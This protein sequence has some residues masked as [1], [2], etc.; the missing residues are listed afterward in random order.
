MSIPI[1]PSQSL[2]ELAAGVLLGALENQST[3]LA[4]RLASATSSM[5]ERTARRGSAYSEGL[6]RG[7]T[8]RGSA[9]DSVIERRAE[10]L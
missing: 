7:L 8:Q 5:I 2:P 3:E 10:S 6:L 9:E 1:R 4:S